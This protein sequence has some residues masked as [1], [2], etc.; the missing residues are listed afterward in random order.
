MP[1]DGNAAAY[2]VDRHLQEGRAGKIAFHEVSGA[3]GELTD[4]SGRVAAALDRSGI[5]RE[6]RAVMLLLDQIEFPQIFWG[7]LKA[8]VVP[9]PLN[10]LLSTPVYDVIFQDCRASVL[11]VSEELLPVVAPL[12]TDAPF[13]RKVIIVGDNRTESA[14]PFAEFAD[15]CQPVP[16]VGASADEV[17][18]WLY[19]SGSNGQRRAFAMFT[20]ACG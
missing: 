17:A 20:P 6:E 5:R 3:G 11:F 16:T 18:F 19:S 4:G 13:L 2:F 8:G 10:T 14:E 1:H 15:G 12:L 9:V 7:C